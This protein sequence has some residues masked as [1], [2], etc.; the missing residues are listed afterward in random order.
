MSINRLLLSFLLHAWLSRMT[1]LELTCGAGDRCLLHSR[2][3]SLAASCR[4]KFKCCEFALRNWLYKALEGAIQIEV[5]VLKGFHFDVVPTYVCQMSGL[6]RLNMQFTL[7]SDLPAELVNLSNLESLNVSNNK[8]TSVPAV[9][10]Q[11]THLQQIAVVSFGHHPSGQL[12]RPL[13]FLSTFGNLRSFD[14]SEPAES[15]SC[16]SMFYI[17]QLHA[18]LDKAFRH[19]L[20]SDKPTND[21]RQQLD[22][23]PQSPSQCTVR[24]LCNSHWTTGSSYTCTSLSYTEFN[25]NC[26]QVVMHHIVCSDSA[27]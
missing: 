23:Q 14:L 24:Y 9:L 13:T 25:V 27:F 6:K 5:L 19:R 7:V 20:P 21:Y 4:V 8:L 3:S 26:V 22:Q 12:T 17:G 15:W 16:S 10:E 11:M 1:L 2:S 18:A